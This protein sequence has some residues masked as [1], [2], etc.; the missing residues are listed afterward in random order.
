M[1][2]S[3]D[4]PCFSM[5]KTQIKLRTPFDA[6]RPIYLGNLAQDLY[7]LMDFNGHAFPQLIFSSWA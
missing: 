5:T 2:D 1:I 3:S 7:I 6:F 4:M